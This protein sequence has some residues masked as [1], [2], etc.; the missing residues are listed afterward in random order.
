MQSII[1]IFKDEGDAGS[2]AAYLDGLSAL[3]TITA[4]EDHTGSLRKLMDLGIRPSVVIL[5]SRLYPGE[6]PDLAATVRTFFPGAELLILSSLEE[7]YPALMQLSADSV[8]HLQVDSP[9]EEHHGK[10]Y[11]ESVLAKLRGGRPIT[12]SDRLASPKAVSVFD[13]RASSQKEELLEKLAA[14]LPGE[15]DDLEM[16]RQRGALLADELIENALYGAP[17]DATG[18]KLFSKGQARDTLPGER[19]QFSFGFDGETL[20]LEMT[21]NWG[22]LDP[23]LVVEYLAR[24]QAQE[25]NLD[26][27]GGRGLFLIWRFFDHFHISVYPGVK[28]VVGGDLALS[29]GLDLEAPRGFHITEHKKAHNITEHLKGEAA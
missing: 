3:W 25:G 11:F 15:G 5:S 4:D 27:I 22:T 12:V 10:G 7:E 8:R 14:A 1:A 26:E 6:N 19:L 20:A 18:E 17:K 13:V 2:W 23:D 24:N 16:F 21:D 28:T 9:G 29:R